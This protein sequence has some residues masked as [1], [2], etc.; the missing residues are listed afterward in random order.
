MDGDTAKKLA[1]N[2]QAIAELAEN[3]PLLMEFVPYIVN[4]HMAYY[5]EL[6]KQGF[7]SDQ[8]IYLVAQHGTSFG[9]RGS[10]EKT[11]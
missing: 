9:L 6:V 3:L 1:K 10:Q 4:A 5:K 2:E 8:A 11:G 7:S